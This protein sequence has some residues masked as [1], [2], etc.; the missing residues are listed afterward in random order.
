MG[1]DGLSKIP[2]EN[3]EKLSERSELSKKTLIVIGVFIL[4]IGAVVIWF[5]LK[6][7]N[8]S[9]ISTA[10]EETMAQFK[11]QYSEATGIFSSGDR[12]E[13]IEAFQKLLPDAPNKTEEGKLKILLASQLFFRNDNGDRAEAV[14]LYKSVINDFTMPPYVRAIALNN[15]AS[16]IVGQS[17][18][19]YKLHFP[20]PPFNEF[21]PS[22]GSDN[23]KLTHAYMKI[24]ELSR[25]TYDT[26][27]AAYEI[28]GNYYAPAL[29]IV[30]SNA[31]KERV[32]GMTEEDAARLIERYVSEGDELKDEDLHLP[33]VN[34]EKYLFRALALNT[35]GRV[36]N[37]DLEEREEGFKRVLQY[38]TRYDTGSYE[39]T[40]EV[41]LQARFFYADF[42]SENFG[43]ERHNDIREILA[44]FGAAARGT[45][46]SSVKTRE[47]FSRRMAAQ[48][49]NIVKSRSGNL[50][51]ISPEFKEFFANLVY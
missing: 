2:I 11:E 30:P 35:S 9:P 10:P 45:D 26:S 41:L 4:I 27:A 1:D 43:E 29:S 37:R 38:G 33:H 19:F 42:L 34:A 16:S 44:P 36:L 18:S 15:V 49:G 28:A 7:Q 13:A 24:L 47:Y 50:I 39:K 48:S 3:P 46:F 14:K 6:T 21:I 17:I 12:D 8:L 22:T 40:Q 32:A 23:F 31:R 25:D 20:E 5:F 51:E